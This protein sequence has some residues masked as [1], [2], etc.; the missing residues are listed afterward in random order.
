MSNR[1]KAIVKPDILIWARTT[2]GFEP[3]AVDEALKFKSGSVSS[4]ESDD[5]NY[6]P[7][8]PQL[9]KLADLYKRPLAVFYLQERPLTFQPMRDLRA[10]V[11]TGPRTLAP[12]LTIEIRKAEQQRE[13]ALELLSDLGETPSPFTLEASRQESP[14]TIGQ[15]I[16]DALKVT[17]EAQREWKSPDGRL[18]YNHWRA[19]M[20]QFHVLV[21]QATRFTEEDASGFA[22]SHPTL[23]VIVINRRNAPSRRTYSLLHEFAHLM[24]RVSG[25]SDLDPDITYRTDDQRL[26][27]FCNQIAAAALM[28]GG[29]FLSHPLIAHAGAGTH[30]WTNDQLTEIAASF[31]VSREAALV[32]LMSFGR[33]TAAHYREFR[34]LLRNQYIEQK[35]RMRNIKIEMK[36]NMPQETLSNLGRP[37][38]NFVLTNY[39]QDRLTLSE[40]GGYLGIKTR[41]IRKLEEQAGLR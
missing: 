36:R 15:R 27:V 26:E 40:V 1:I 13:L 11:A 37:F 5:A 10:P 18:A 8:I 31:G 17:T 41:H 38:V 20:E 19:R 4:W 3:A 24:L 22:L 25:V 9:R 16:R 29:E 2:A 33:A 28:P 14:E 30:A 12:A 23:P 7:S 39:H 32:R 34:E 6:A 21:F 35:Q